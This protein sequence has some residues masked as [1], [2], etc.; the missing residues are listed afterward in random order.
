[1]LLASYNIQYGLGR[2][3]AY[4]IPR[5]ARAVEAADIIALQEV[6]R[7]F[8]LNSRADQPAEFGAL[9]NRYWVYGPGFDVDNST[10]DPAGRVTN[11]RRQFGNMVLSRWPIRASRNILL[12]R[13]PYHG[14]FDIARSALEVVIE[15]PAGAFRIYSVHLSHIHAE[16]RARQLDCLIDQIGRAP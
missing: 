2:D 7:G 13:R 5:L 12:P 4:D 3:N 11:R 16:Q 14:I 9:L 10:V 1:M 15:T 6:V 8:D